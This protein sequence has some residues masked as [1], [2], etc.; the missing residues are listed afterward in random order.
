MKKNEKLL[1][2]LGDIP[3]KYID[4]ALDNPV[5]KA[6]TN[7]KKVAVLAACACAV[8]AVSLS[9]L[10]KNGSVDITKEEKGDNSILSNSQ[11]EPRTSLS[12]TDSSHQ[13][14]GNTSEYS[15]MT[16]EEIM[17]S[18]TLEQKAYQMIEPGLNEIDSYSM[19]LRDYG[20]VAAEYN[21]IN[22]YLYRT[23][24]D[25]FQK[26]AVKSDSGIPFLFGLDSVG[27]VDYCHESVI[28]P[29]NIGLG[30]AND[31]QLVYKAG[32]AAADEGTMCHI[33][34]NYSPCVSYSDDPRW[35]N[36][37]E[38]FSSDPEIVKSL[39]SSY[40]M[41]LEEG[42][43][44][45]CAKYYFGDPMSNAGKTNIDISG[46][47]DQNENIDP[48]MISI[49]QTQVD[50][51]VQSVMISRDSLKSEKTI[52]TETFISILKDEMGFEGIVVSDWDA[53]RY[54]KGSTY[55]EQIINTVNSGIDMMM[56]TEKYDEAAKIIVDAVGSGKITQQRVDDAVRRIIQ[57][58]MD[59]GL[60]E[61][62][63]QE[64]RENSQSKPGSSEYREIAEKLVEESLV[65]L[66][67]D[68]DTLPLKKGTSV[69]ITGPACDNA[70]VQCGASGNSS[71]GI[72]ENDFAGVTTI[73]EGFENRAEEFGI[74]IITD[75]NDAGSADVVLLVV[76]EMTGSDTDDPS[77]YGSSALKEN[78]EACDDV[79]A[80]G[81]P[82]ITCIVAGRNVFLNEEDL[83]S[84]DSV[85]MCYL[86][87][88]EGQGVADV[89]CGKENF[90]G[91]LPSPWYNSVDQIGTGN[92]RFEKGYGLKY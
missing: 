11:A 64:K 70:K 85:V 36:T 90:K 80:L 5:I 21:N 39:S 54:F 83:N 7:W 63:F 6:K 47:A 17:A 16:A 69:Y 76:G 32:L 4:K 51:G 31:P 67:N 79:R 41:G 13:K 38:C 29:H 50:A 25:E 55:R 3:Q 72:S 12:D 20:G 46:S 66:K 88:S 44:A 89:L 28:F 52:E 34:W 40:T 33:L 14:N 2:D 1:Y 26:S 81:K 56:L 48:E 45:A 75:K 18:L 43:A 62:P 9:F 24:L 10:L 84:W 19:L 30:A 65:L 22:Y 49:F 87:G 59:K 82:V 74:N 73:L 23:A 15:T 42:G 71:S 78:A 27:D 58:K 68:S 60:F 91:T 57:V 92:C 61:D 86:P 53:A 35:G 37:Y 77:L 8:F